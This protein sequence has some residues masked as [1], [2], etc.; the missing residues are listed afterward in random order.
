MK[1]IRPLPLLFL[2]FVISVGSFWH[3]VVPTQAKNPLTY[4]VED[5]SEPIIPQIS[6]PVSS[7]PSTK[8][9]SFP[10]EAMAPLYWKDKELFPDQLS[11][12]DPLVLTGL[13]G[14]T[15]PN[16]LLTFEGLG[17]D[18][19]T[20][21]DPVGDVGPNHYVQMVNVSFQIWDKGNPAQG[22]A[23]TILHP[24]T[25]FNQLFVGNGGQCE[26]RNDGA[27]I[28][29]YDDQADRWL[30]S[31]FT[32]G[33][34]FTICVAV[35]TTPDPTGT[36]YL[37]EFPMPAYPDYPKLSAWTDA[38]YIGTN[39]GVPHEFF[40]HA[41]DRNRMLAGL[42]ATRQS[43][44]NLD[45]FVLPA[46]LD[47]ELPPPADSPGIFYTMFAEGY[48][49]HPTGVDRL[50]VYEFEV[51]WEQPANTTFSLV[52][53]LPIAAFN[54]TVCGYL[55]QAC[56]PQPETEQKLDSLSYWPMF[57]FQYRNF[58]NFAAMVG[59]FTVDVDGQ[60]TAGIRWFEIHK[61]GSTYTLH[62]EGTYAPNSTHRWMGSIAMDKRRN[63][64]LGYNA[65]SETTPPSIR[66]TSRL[67][68]DP[69]GTLAAEAEMWTGTGVQ[70]GTVRW[71][72]YSNL[73]VDPVDGC[74]FWFTAEYHDEDDSGFNWNT[75]VGV[76]K[77]PGCEGDRGT[78]TGQ[79]MDGTSEISGAQIHAQAYITETEIVSTDENGFY[80]MVL[81]EGSYV[82]TAT[83]YGFIPDVVSGVT[84]FSG[85][86]TLQNFT[87]SPAPVYIITGT[88]VDARAGWPMYAAIHISNYPGSPI[89]T[90]PGTG[91]Y[92]VALPEGTYTFEVLAWHSGYLPQR[93]DVE[94]AGNQR[95]EIALHVEPMLCNAPGY[96]FNGTR[97]S[98]E[99]GS[100]P[101]GWTVVDNIIRMKAQVWQFNNPAGRAN[102]T[103]G[104]GL[105][106]IMDS[107]S[108]GPGEVQDSSL[109]TPLLDFSSLENV[110][111]SFDTDFKVFEDNSTNEKAHVNLSP[112]GGQTWVNVWAREME[113]GDFNGHVL[114]DV[115]A[116]AAYQPEVLI[117]FRYFDAEY[118]YWWQVDNVAYG[119][120]SCDPLPGGWIVGNVLDEN[121]ETGLNGLPIT[122]TLPTTSTI[123]TTIATPHDPWLADGFY[124]Y[125][126]LQGP[127]TLT[128][129]A[130]QYGV[131]AHTLEIISGTTT[132]Q[133]FALPAG[134]L[135]FTPPEVFMP[136]G[137]GYTATLSLDMT[138]LGGL[139]A[140]FQLSTTLG[141]DL[142]A[143]ASLHPLSGTIPSRENQNFL[144]V[145]STASLTQTG[146][147][148]GTFIFET[149][150]P[151][152]NV[153]LPVTLLVGE[154]NPSVSSSPDQTQIGMPGTTLQYTLAITNT[155]NIPDWFEILLS[156]YEW[157]T[158]TNLSKIFLNPGSHAMIEISVDIPL[159]TI[160][161]ET[162]NLTIHI[163]GVGS[164]AKTSTTIQTIAQYPYVQFFT[165][166][167]NKT[168]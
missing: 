56:I 77:L 118:D 43:I 140:S 146:A 59:N 14:G 15:A 73:V 142:Q 115:S 52:Q 63:I 42:P 100:L 6:P 84:V 166:I 51:D 35:S 82:V 67:V 168:E 57:R 16:P 75:R 50:A 123:L 144:M 21:P 27:P 163:N 29:L 48:P 76:F 53:E 40:A 74:H 44:G 93:M 83:A 79:V 36:Y 107:D 89:R 10:E 102:L 3:S 62:Q 101:P 165:L 7:L 88:V 22:I 41:L 131:I 24:D 151:Y 31:Q 17:S 81:P 153:S 105:F 119:A 159:N 113:G 80:S 97:E 68:T 167:F 86:N 69:L 19:L 25:L 72:D 64:A 121:F 37:Y 65:T 152:G 71:G 130:P 139:S 128:T 103:G 150:T 60:D 134:W 11:N 157:P 106:A 149:T 30:L 95:V 12:P 1:N 70:T 162:D 39:S 38:Y 20:P 108:F 54:Y 26:T 94:V 96:V 138:N 18:G 34:P 112:D 49:N 90:D 143:W 45:N 154:P 137:L 109:I 155:G 92:Q 147:Y 110:F 133:D 85:T 2:F 4:F 161:Q 58:G 129:T 116:Y 120:L 23:P 91:F 125:F 158:S 8:Q 135:E 148:T 28:V 160:Y 136:L 98:F 145:L 164:G 99:T 114:L 104:T 156:N 66:F 122:I 32:L 126:T 87:L 78:L 47:G 33:N 111:L 61:T 9:T 46:D 127:I 117:E 13:N 5:V 141:T 55:V 124:S 132:R